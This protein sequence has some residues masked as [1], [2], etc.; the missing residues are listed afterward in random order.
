M[1]T[2]LFY[3]QIP[4]TRLLSCLPQLIIVVMKVTPE[5]APPPKFYILGEL[6][7]EEEA[8]PSMLVTLDPQ[9]K[10]GS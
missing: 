5:Y 2:A 3:G 6:E 10:K 9:V 8:C 7:A 4:I 1:T